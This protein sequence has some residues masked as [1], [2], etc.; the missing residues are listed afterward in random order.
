ME[1]QDGEVAPTCPVPQSKLIADCGPV[2]DGQKVAQGVDHHVADHEDALPGAAFFKEM[3]DG[4]FFGD[5]KIVGERVGQ[6]A[7]DLL[8]HGAVKTAEAGFDVSHADSK[9]GGSERNGDGGIDVADN[10]NDIRLALDKN[11]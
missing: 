2:G 8:R 11:R 9:L 5:K 3:S 1:R 10:E 6:D 7:I 4:V